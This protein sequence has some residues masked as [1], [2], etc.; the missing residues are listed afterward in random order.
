MVSQA[1]PPAMPLVFPPH[2][3]AVQLLKLFSEVMGR[4]VDDSVKEAIESIRSDADDLSCFVYIYVCT[5][6]MIFYV[7]VL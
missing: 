2:L 7:C 3:L 1:T 5:C 4:H 6:T